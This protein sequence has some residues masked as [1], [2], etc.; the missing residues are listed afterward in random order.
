[1]HWL[2]R[3]IVCHMADCDEA[4]P[5]ALP[6][7]TIDELAHA[8]GVTVRTIRAHQARGLLPPPDV[9]ARTGFYGPEHRAR[10]ELIKDL[11]AEGVRLDTIAK[12]LETTAG[13]TGQ[14]LHFLR[15]VRALF[16]EP[17]GLIIDAAELAARFGSSDPQLLRKAQKAGLL[18]EVTD[19]QYQEVSPRLMAAGQSLVDLGVPVARSLDV[20]GRLRRHAD[21]I[22]RL[23]VDV[24]LDEVWRPFDAAGR[25]AEQ[26]P[27]IHDGL[28]QL[29]TL[30]GESLL[31][32]VETAVGA[33]LG[34]T[35][36]REIT[37]NV[38]TAPGEVAGAR[39]VPFDT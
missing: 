25:P 4:V 18:R 37:R 2:L 9:R 26:W 8:T 13:S 27:R 34:V 12:L 10:L 5:G 11:Q 29:R 33:R 1:M 16:A 32:V 17:E 22:A 21:G 3:R 35:F 31:A 7:L 38:R 23:Y 6:W 20:V 24:F 39:G 15:E 30:A 19:G 28:T 36:G 14:V